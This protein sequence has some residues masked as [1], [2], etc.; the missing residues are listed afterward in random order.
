MKYDEIVYVG[1]RIP[2]PMYD[3]I[4]KVA[5]TLGFVHVSSGNPNT[6]KMIRHLL[7]LGLAM[8]VG[9]DKD[10]RDSTALREKD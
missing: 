6:T 2:R 3:Q 9:K 1:I 10:G 4:R 8:V 5:S 7:K